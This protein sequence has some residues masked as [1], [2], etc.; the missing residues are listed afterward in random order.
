MV[1]FWTGSPCIASEDEQQEGEVQALP[2]P[3]FDVLTAVDHRMRWYAE[4]RPAV[5]TVLRELRPRY[6][7]MLC[8]G[9]SM[10]GFAAVLHGGLIADGVLALNPQANLPEA[11]LRPPAE[12]PRDLQDLSESLLDSAKA[13][14]AR[15][16]QV[17]VHSAADEHLLHACTLLF[18]KNVLVIHPLQPRKPF[19]RI[20]DRAKLLLPIVSDAVYRV[21]T[22]AEAGHAVTVGCWCRNGRVKRVS[23]EPSQMLKLFYGPGAGMLPR[24]GDW[25]CGHCRARNCRDRWFCWR[26][27]P[28]GSV[29]SPMTTPG[30]LRVLDSFSYPSKWD[31]GCTRCAAALCGYEHKCSYCGADRPCPNFPK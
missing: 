30:T 14:A 18:G 15:G 25:F 7:K 26:C 13:A 22:G 31:W 28:A 9:A 21:L 11:L 27:A 1:R 29:G 4:D 6:S 8:V 5:E 23:A 17:T 3:D 24:P 16:A 10:G 19:A 20:L 12:T 2:L